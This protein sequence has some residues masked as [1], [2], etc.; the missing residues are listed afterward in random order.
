MAKMI[1]PDSDQ[2]LEVEPDRQAMYLSAGWRLKAAPKKTTVAAP[3]DG[4]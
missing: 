1:H 4:K 3:T 2:T